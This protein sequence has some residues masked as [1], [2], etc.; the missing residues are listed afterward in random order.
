MQV[1]GVSKAG[2]GNLG[3]LESTESMTGAIDRRGGKL[4]R[5]GAQSVFS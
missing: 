5:S 4:L 2:Y 1:G 3:T